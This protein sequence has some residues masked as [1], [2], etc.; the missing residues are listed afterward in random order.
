MRITF[1]YILLLSCGMTYSQNRNS[2]WCFGDSAG[3]D[4]RNLNNPAPIITSFDTRGS[5]VSIAKSIGELIFY[6]NTRATMGDHSTLV[7]DSSNQIMQNGSNIIGEGWYRELVIVPFP[8]D[9]NLF[10]L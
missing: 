5:C 4:F 1:L 10:Y 9:T 6:S 3:I 8:N 7:W 2:I